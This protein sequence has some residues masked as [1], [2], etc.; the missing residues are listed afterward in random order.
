MVD[1]VGSGALF[2]TAPFGLGEEPT[3]RERVQA[4]ADVTIVDREDAVAPPDKAAARAAIRASAQVE[5]L[6]LRRGL[7]RLRHNDLS[8]AVTPVTEPITRVGLPAA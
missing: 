7:D 1:D 4:G 5:L 2:P 8:Y 6:R 3:V